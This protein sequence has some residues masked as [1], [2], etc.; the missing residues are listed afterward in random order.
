MVKGILAVFF[1]A[2]SYGILSTI[3]KLS[4]VNGFKA[5]DATLFQIVFLLW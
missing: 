5:T 3:A 1:G 2:A 4:Y